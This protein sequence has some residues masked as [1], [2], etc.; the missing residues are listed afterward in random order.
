MNHFELVYILKADLTKQTQEKIDNTM[1]KSIKDFGGKIIDR[2]IWGLKDLSYPIKNSKKGFY[3]FLQV[4]IDSI[5]L[6]NINQAKADI[7]YFYKKYPDS[8]LLKYVNYEQK[9]INRNY[10]K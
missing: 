1:E 5:K 8:N 2:E 9:I 3:I 4:D 10:E 7:D 6:K